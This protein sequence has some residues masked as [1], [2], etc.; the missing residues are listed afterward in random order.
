[1]SLKSALA[2][3]LSES[4]DKVET[5][6][7]SWLASSR[8]LILI[9]FGLLIYFAKSVFTFELFVLMASVVG[10]YLVCNTATR[11]VEIIVEG[12]LRSE[13][14]RLAWT[15]GV[16][17]AAEV[18]VIKS[19]DEIAAGGAR[20]IAPPKTSTAVAVPTPSTDTK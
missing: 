15:D 5:V 18:E 11:I 13:R 14:Q 16:L 3:W 9:A 6:E 19:A 7:K 10:L 20:P 17:T 4:A 1:M 2:G 8:F 12:R